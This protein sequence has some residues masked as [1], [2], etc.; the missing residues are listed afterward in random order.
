MTYTAGTGIDVSG[1]NVISNTGVLSV[2]AT[3]PLSSTGGANPS[4]SLSSGSAN[5]DILVWDND[6]GHWSIVTPSGDVLVSKTGVTTIQPNAV[7][8]GTDTTGNYVATVSGSGPIGVSGSG[9]ETA[10]VTV[11]C[12]TCVTSPGGTLAALSQ[13]HG[14]V[15]FSYDGT[16]AQTVAVDESQ[17]DIS[18]MTGLLDLTSQVTGVLPIADGGT[19]NT[20]FTTG[21]F[22]AYDGTKLASTTYGPSS[23]IAAGASLFSSA[24]NTGGSSI[25]NGDTLTIRGDG[26]ILTSADNGSG[27]VAFSLNQGALSLQLIGGSLDLTSQVTGVLP[28]SNGGTN[29]TSFTTDTLTYFDGTKLASTSINPSDVVT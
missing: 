23:F 12:P 18:L 3:A 5:G 27:V 8:L 19:D 24:G 21:K 14:V 28:I 20:S 7:A 2:G 1:G 13:G 6:A 25:S 11:S 17:L 9:S 10:A 29:N 4:I 26:T 15:A 16:S 22:L